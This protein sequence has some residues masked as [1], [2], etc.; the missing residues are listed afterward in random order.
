MMAVMASSMTLLVR[1]TASSSADSGAGGAGGGGGA[2][3]SGGGASGL[4]GGGGASGFAGAADPTCRAISAA[5]CSAVFSVPTCE[6]TAKQKAATKHPYSS[7]SA[8]LCRD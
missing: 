2:S 7:V 4:G 6:W 8:P 3:G 1:A 5:F